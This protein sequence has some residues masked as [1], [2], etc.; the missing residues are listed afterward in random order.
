MWRD[1]AMVTTGGHT[2]SFVTVYSHGLRFDLSQ[3]GKLLFDPVA[4]QVLILIYL[5]DE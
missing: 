2:G 5:R 1:I 3:R 4:Q